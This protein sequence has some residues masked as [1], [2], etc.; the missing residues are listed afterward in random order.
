MRFLLVR[1]SVKNISNAY[2]GYFLPHL[3]PSIFQSYTDARSHGSDNVSR[4]QF[5]GQP[6]SVTSSRARWSNSKHSHHKLPAQT[7][8][9]NRRQRQRVVAGIFVRLWSISPNS[10]PWRPEGFR[11]WLTLLDCR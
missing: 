10:N 11:V 7:R 9:S 6:Q 4:A 3:T 8:A 2:F 5:S 1:R